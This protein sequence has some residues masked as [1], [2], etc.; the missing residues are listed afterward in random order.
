[1]HVRLFLLTECLLLIKRKAAAVIARFRGSLWVLLFSNDILKANVLFSD[2]FQSSSLGALAAAT[3][4]RYP[5]IP[6]PSL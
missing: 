5:V 6:A 4:M 1:M 2:G 3:V